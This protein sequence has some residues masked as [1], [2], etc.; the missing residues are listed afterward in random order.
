M[1]TIMMDIP[2]ET[3]LSEPHEKRL[4]IFIALR[5]SLGDRHEEIMAELMT[6]ARRELEDPCEDE[7]QPDPSLI[8]KEE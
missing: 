5:K 6:E 4:G 3:L 7:G 1:T 2:D 8:P